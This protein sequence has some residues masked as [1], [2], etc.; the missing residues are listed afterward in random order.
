MSWIRRLLLTLR[1]T[2]W[3]TCHDLLGHQRP[4]DHKLRLQSFGGDFS[5]AVNKKKKH[6][7]KYPHWRVTTIITIL[8]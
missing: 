2:K 1:S 4:V 7:G 5:Y 3:T 8:V 6:R